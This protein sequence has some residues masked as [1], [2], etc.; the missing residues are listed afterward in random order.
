MQSFNLKA[1]LD[2]KRRPWGCPQHLETWLQHPS[3]SEITPPLTLLAFS[4]LIFPKIEFLGKIFDAE[5]TQE[6]LPWI[7]VGPWG[8]SSTH[9]QPHCCHP[10]ASTNT[11]R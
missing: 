6:V 5:L 10:R 8:S 3:L 2:M 7:A 1:N 4:N 11:K 9:T